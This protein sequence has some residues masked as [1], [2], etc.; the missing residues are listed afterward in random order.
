M[1]PK[2][3]TPEELE[4]QLDKLDSRDAEFA[5]VNLVRCHIAA[6]EAEIAACSIPVNRTLNPMWNCFVC[7]NEPCTCKTFNE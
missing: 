3:L 1:T 2:R 6:L 7:H 5:D 4:N